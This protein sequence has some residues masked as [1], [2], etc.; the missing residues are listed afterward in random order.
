M[1]MIF[2]DDKEN[3]DKENITNLLTM[4][5][6]YAAPACVVE[7]ARQKDWA[8]E[9][10][11]SIEDPEKFWGDYASTFEWSNAWSDVSQT[12]GVSHQ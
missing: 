11:R 10:K 7:Q 4:T 9:Y 12:D 6:E 5:E 8:G 3:V 1:A 2:P